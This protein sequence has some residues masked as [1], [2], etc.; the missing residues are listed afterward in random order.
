M[1]RKTSIIF[2]LFLIA[3]I[4]FL[5]QFNVTP[6]KIDSPYT[7]DNSTQNQ[8]EN[9]KEKQQNILDI[10]KQIEE[11]MRKEQ[12]I[13]A[14]EERLLRLQDVNLVLSNLD[15]VTGLK[16]DV[17][18]GIETYHNV[19]N[20]NGTI[21][22]KG[23]EAYLVYRFIIGVDLKLNEWQVDTIEGDVITLKIPEIKPYLKSLEEKEDVSYIKDLYADKKWFVKRYKPSE[24]EFIRD[25]AI[26]YIK[27]KIND[28]PEIWEK[29]QEGID[30]NIETI[31]QFILG[32]GYSEVYFNLE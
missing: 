12:A 30:D 11:Q 29:A 9:T 2:I 13:K 8:T 5:L 26:K 15:K 23:L 6:K 3:I 1:K 22:K 7:A 32:L 17:C 18:E 31:R 21:Y 24:T 27:V 10:Q 14:E 19:I 16:I 4:I 25:Y 20:Q 28:S